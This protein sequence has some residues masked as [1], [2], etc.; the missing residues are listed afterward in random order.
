MFIGCPVFPRMLLSSST[1]ESRSSLD[2]AVEEADKRGVDVI[3]GKRWF[4]VKSGV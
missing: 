1:E 2:E 4:P 3:A